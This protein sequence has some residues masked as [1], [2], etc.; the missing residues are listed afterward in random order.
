MIV[1]DLVTFIAAYPLLIVSLCSVALGQ[2]GSCWAFEEK[3]GDT[4]TVI[5]GATEFIGAFP[6]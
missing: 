6:Q 5:D 4:K 1:P 3:I 2:C